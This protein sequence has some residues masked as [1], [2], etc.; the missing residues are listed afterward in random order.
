MSQIYLEIIKEG[1]LTGK[2]TECEEDPEKPGNLKPCP[3]NEI[4]PDGDYPECPGYYYIPGDGEE[5]IDVDAKIIDDEGNLLDEIYDKET[6]Q[7]IYTKGE[8][9]KECS[10][11]WALLKPGGCFG[12]NT[13]KGHHLIFNPKNFKFKK[14]KI[15]YKKIPIHFR[16]KKN[17]DSVGCGLFVD[18]SRKNLG[19]I[20]HRA[21]PDM[22][23]RSVMEI[24]DEVLAEWQRLSNAGEERKSR[25]SKSKRGKNTAGIDTQEIVIA[26]TSH[27]DK[28]PN[29]K[30]RD[31]LRTLACNLLWQGIVLN[32]VE[33][34]I[35][36]I[37][38]N[39]TE[40][41]LNEAE[42]EGAIFATLPAYIKEKKIEAP[43]L[44]VKNHKNMGKPAIIRQTAKAMGYEFRR[45]I[46]KDGIDWKLESSEDW[47]TNDVSDVR[48]WLTVE[49]QDKTKHSLEIEFKY[50]RRNK[51]ENQFVSVGA[52][53]KDFKFSDLDLKRTFKSIMRENSFDPL[54]D[55]LMED[56]DNVREELDKSYQKLGREGV[57]KEWECFNAHFD[58][59]GFDRPDDI[60]DPGFIETAHEY[61]QWLLYNLIA[62]AIH[63]TIQTEPKEF[64][65]V[66][67]VG[68]EGCYKSSLPKFMLPKHLRADHFKKATF[69]MTPENL[70][71]MFASAI[72]VEFAEMVG[73][74]ANPNRTKMIMSELKDDWTRKYKEG[75][76]S[77]FRLCSWMLSS[78]DAQPLSYSAD[79]QRRYYVIYLYR[80]KEITERGQKEGKF[81]GD[82]VDYLDEWAE[83][84]R[85]RIWHQ[86]LYLIKE[87]EWG[88][89]L[90][91]NELESLRME[92]VRKA[93]GYEDFEKQ[94]TDAF[95]Y[96]L[97]EGIRAV[98]YNM[99][100]SQC[101][102]KRSKKKDTTI[103]EIYQKMGGPKEMA[104]GWYSPSDKEEEFP[105][106][107]NGRYFDMSP[108]DGFRECGENVLKAI[109]PEQM[110]GGLNG[111]K[112]VSRAR[113][114]SSQTEN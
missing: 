21:F 101:E 5:G 75:C 96:Y 67:M 30:R 25:A 44:L 112:K 70:G 105:K 66:V 50:D 69:L 11:I 55:W 28:I 31:T 35:K 38:Q 81:L 43:F 90:P 3:Y 74:H 102:T 46:R 71:R 9:L 4:V 85:K 24:D 91:N 47:K 53:L 19:K 34:V 76:E 63:N 39:N 59:L 37:N 18:L 68:P 65:V 20:T 42:L 27:D 33:S 26:S 51:T 95:N 100:Y 114:I 14:N 12:N 104:R 54:M 57:L 32:D 94:V 82:Y 108:V 23:D 10:E 92:Y 41:P 8:F 77:I 86:I 103:R 113:C 107:I 109:R 83:K 110:N 6:G 2:L 58:I 97:D 111:E 17:K 29:G 15:Y 1:R 62:P 79:N 56:Y 45:N 36:S 52:K 48:D 87:Q 40:T 22:M 64:P 60:K 89:G 16:G 49:A 13:G 7:L 106:R 84:H 98:D 88:L 93:C 61:N 78:N 73:F 80:K 99:V 72:F